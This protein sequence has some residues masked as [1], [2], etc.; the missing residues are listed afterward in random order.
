V[1]RSPSAPLPVRRMKR[2]STREL[3]QSR[4][5]CDSSPPSGLPLAPVEAIHHALYCTQSICI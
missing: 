1:Q 3:P 5:M 2:G 4:N